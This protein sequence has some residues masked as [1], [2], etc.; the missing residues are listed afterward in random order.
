MRSNPTPSPS[1][2]WIIARWADGWH[3]VTHRSSGLPLGKLTPHFLCAYTA[4]TPTGVTHSRHRTRQDA[5]RWLL[6]QFVEINR[7]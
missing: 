3:Q 6:R 7:K 4:V 5:A 1:S 2:P